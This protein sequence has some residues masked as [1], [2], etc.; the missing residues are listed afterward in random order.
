MQEDTQQGEVAREVLDWC[1]EMKRNEEFSRGDYSIAL[2]L[3]LVFLG[4]FVPNF[5]IPRPGAVST[6]TS[7][8]VTQTGF[9][10]L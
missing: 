9:N 7:Y 4:I 2:N 6:I 10:S 1:Q 8:D 3:V 5:S